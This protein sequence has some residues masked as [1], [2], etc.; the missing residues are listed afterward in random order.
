MDMVSRM[1]VMKFFNV[2]LARLWRRRC[3][4]V[5]ELNELV[6]KYESKI[7]KTHDELIK[8]NK[9]ICHEQ[10]RCGHWETELRRVQAVSDLNMRRCVTIEKALNVA[11][12]Q[13]LHL[14][15][16]L[17]AKTL[18]CNNASDLL[19]ES[20]TEMFRELSKHRECAKAL[21]EQQRLNRW[22]EIR[23]VELEDELMTLK[24]RF[25]SQHD[26][27]SVAMHK[28]KLQLD[29]TYERLKDFEQQL[30]EFQL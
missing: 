22:L 8:R 16:E 17:Q 13:R 7:N 27:V 18:E 23:N 1:R 21:A 5:C 9:M 10:R 28:S 20:R 14:S 24:D 25:Q 15:K 6:R 2:I 11:C 30:T 12:G 19:N 4:E 3:S 26:D 29:D